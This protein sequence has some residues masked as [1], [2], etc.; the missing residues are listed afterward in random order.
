MV[1]L[2]KTVKDVTI[3]GVCSKSKHEALKNA[4]TIDHLLERGADYSNEVRKYVNDTYIAHMIRLVKYVPS[5]Y[6]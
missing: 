1:Q 5:R 4:G 2:A 6:S 3:F